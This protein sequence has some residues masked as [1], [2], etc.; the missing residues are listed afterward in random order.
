LPWYSWNIAESGIKHPKKKS[1]QLLDYKEFDPVI[2]YIYICSTV[3]QPQNN[4]NIVESGV[5]HH[6]LILSMSKF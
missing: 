5:K 4:R 3:V 2:C 6:N 1:N